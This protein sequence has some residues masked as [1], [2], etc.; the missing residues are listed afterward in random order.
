VSLR[1]AVAQNAYWVEPVCQFRQRDGQEWLT[2]VFMAP[3][4]GHDQ[5]N[6]V[7]PPGKFSVDQLVDRKDGRMADDQ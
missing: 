6:C 5:F 3:S 2:T 7:S 4:G 1:L